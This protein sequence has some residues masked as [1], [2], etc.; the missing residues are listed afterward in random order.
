MR[1]RSIRTGGMR[2]RER[3]RYRTHAVWSLE[4]VL[5]PC[6]TVYYWRT[7]YKAVCGGKGG[8]EGHVQF[9]GCPVDDRDLLCI[10]L[11]S[12]W[13]ASEAQWFVLLLSLSPLETDEG[14]TDCN[15]PR[16]RFGK[17]TTRFGEKTTRFG[18][19]LPKVNR[20][21]EPVGVQ[22]TPTVTN[23]AFIRLQAESG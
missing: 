1:A 15:L 19:K 13:T 18:K 10:L 11:A 5:S 22:M 2:T 12:S 9:S 7:W 8:S 4:G 6:F 23:E 3:Y 20:S 17:I 14:F 21:P 16:A